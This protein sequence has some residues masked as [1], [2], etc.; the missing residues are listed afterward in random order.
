MSTAP[1]QGSLHGD[2]QHNW[3]VVL[4][5]GEGSRLQVLTTMAS[6]VAVPKQ[7]CSLGG[8]TSLLH[9]ALKRASVI[10]PPERMCVVVAMQHRRWWEGLSRSIPPQNIIVQ[11]RNRGTANGILLSLLRIL[12]RDSDATLLV[13]PSDH[14]VHNEAVLATGL[15]RAVTQAAHQHNG[16]VL[17]GF[18]PEEGDPEL[19]YIVPE[20]DGSCGLREVQQF[21]EK[22]SAAVACELIERGG[23]WNAFIFAV[24]GQALLRI[25]EERCPEIVME[26]RGIVARAVTDDATVDPLLIELYERLPLIDFSRDIV[27]RCASQLLVLGIPA[28]GWSDLGTPR[29]VAE[30]LDRGRSHLAS[31]PE[32]LHGGGFLNLATQYAKLTAAW[33]SGELLRDTG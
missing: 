20:G 7:F 31:S 15:R 23:L 17:L 22:P 28:C 2:A 19:G 5:A 27:G 16:I 1:D 10:A 24:R 25:F 4:A 13:L 11:P 29:R 14:Y 3:A 6:G 18:T 9:D 30:I 33:G 32:P 21:I 26:M 12:Q 8:G